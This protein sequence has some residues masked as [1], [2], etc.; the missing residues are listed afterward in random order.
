ML[1]KFNFFWKCT[2]TLVAT[3]TFYGLFGYEFTV[4]SLIAVLI[5]NQL[6][7]RE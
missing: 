6:R 1:F 7:E 3:W 2:L 5:M 4:V